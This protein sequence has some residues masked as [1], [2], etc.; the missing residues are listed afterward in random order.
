MLRRRTHTI[1]IIQQSAEIGSTAC[2]DPSSYVN[3]DGIHLTDAAYRYIAKGLLN[4]F[5]EYHNEQLQTELRFIGGTP[6]ACC[7][8]G[9]AYN[10][11]SSIGTMRYSTGKRFD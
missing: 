3:W 9:G 7:G 5:V 10:Y 2:K 8:G 11:N 6:K 1:S 4:K